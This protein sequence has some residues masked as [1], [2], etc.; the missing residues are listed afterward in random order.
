MP[1]A[2]SFAESVF[3]KWK[4][5]T[6]FRVER[7]G[8]GGAAEGGREF[9][10]EFGEMRAGEGCEARGGADDY[11]DVEFDSAAGGWGVS[12]VFW[13]VDWGFEGWSEEDVCT[14]RERG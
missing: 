2:P 10:R 4:C 14:C 8:D 3:G 7:F 12:F 13:G 9:G 6:V 11:G 5:E 1:R